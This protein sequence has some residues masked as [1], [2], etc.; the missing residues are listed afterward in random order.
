MAADPI[1]F[2]GKNEPQ[3]QSGLPRQDTAI[4]LKPEI[5]LMKPKPYHHSLT[6]NKI[7]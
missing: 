1:A 7:N 2:E 4:N 3:M 5:H 6:E